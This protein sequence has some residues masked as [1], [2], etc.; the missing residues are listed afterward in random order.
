MHWNPFWHDSSF[1]MNNVA[2]AFALMM[3]S[4]GLS[5]KVD[6]VVFMSVG[7]MLVVSCLLSRITCVS[8]AFPVVL[9]GVLVGVLAASPSQLLIP[10]VVLSVWVAGCRVMWGFKEDSSHRRA[11]VSACLLVV[12]CLAVIGATVSFL[13]LD[14]SVVEGRWP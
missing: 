2:Y 1:L 7:W 12:G 9:N 6:A 11:L 14:F 3:I 10:P 13:G 5:R 8:S 4:C